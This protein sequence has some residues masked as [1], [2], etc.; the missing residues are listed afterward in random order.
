MIRRF[1]GLAVLSFIVLVGCTASPAVPS[2]TRDADAKAIRDGEAAW[3]N[4]WATKDIDR[5]VVHYADD[6]SV[7]IPNIPIM[8]G[9]DAIRTG[10]KQF[11]A[12]S[13]LA[14]TFQ[15]SQVEVAKAGDLAYSRGTY[16]MTMTDPTSKQP[17]TERGKYVT[18]YRKQPDGSWK[19][20]QDINNADASAIPAK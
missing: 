10:L 19:A 11:M 6:A 7:E 15:A 5:I 20:V 1:A 14:L 3:N 2:D 8:T 16:S 18:V 9:K 17:V 13:N 4:D 12:D